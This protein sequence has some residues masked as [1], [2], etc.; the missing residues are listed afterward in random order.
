MY[1]MG[2]VTYCKLLNKS[3]F[4]YG[5]NGINM[6]VSILPLPCKKKIDIAVL[7]NNFLLKW[8]NIQIPTANRIGVW[9]GG[10]LGIC[11]RWIPQPPFLQSNSQSP[12][13]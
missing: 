7:L 3:G 10:A 5:K 12:V 9:A 4:W 6:E 13:Q 8:F 11:P 1:I 2:A